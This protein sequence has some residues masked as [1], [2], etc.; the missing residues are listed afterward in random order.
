MRMTIV[1]VVV[2]VHKLIGKGSV[3]L[4]EGIPSGQCLKEIIKKIVLT[5]TAPTLQRAL[6]TKMISGN[7]VSSFMTLGFW[8]GPGSKCVYN[9]K[10]RK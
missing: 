10:Q 5:S 9:R 1:P 8:L 6:S 2:G 4:M 3:R 7:V